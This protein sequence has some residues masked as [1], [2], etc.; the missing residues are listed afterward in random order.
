MLIRLLCLLF[1]SHAVQAN[2]G[3]DYPSI[4][5]CDE[6][7]FHWYCDLE[8][9]EK[10]KR[11][12]TPP[13][14]INDLKTAEALRL[15]LK[16][17]EDIAIM[18]PTD[19]HIKDYLTLWHATQEKGAIFADNWR[20]VVWQNPDLDYTQK[21]PA[22]NTAVKMYD[23]QRTQNEAQQLKKLAKNHGLIFFFKSDCQYC[24]AMAPTLKMLAGQFGIE[25]L[26]VSLDGKGIP[27]FPNPRDGRAQGAA[28]GVT[29][30]PALFIGSKDTAEHAPIGFGMMALSEI[31]NRIFV[32]TG[33]QPGDNF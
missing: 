15:E 18:Q 5:Q 11:D 2:H 23:V 1:F 19:A 14:D 25:V 30:V 28:W 22:N 9:I 6:D 27:H 26:G 29:R 16:R 31:V 3:L 32:L 24:H 4:W 21:R 12:A 33:S 8:Q 7:K 20:R 13:I 17:R 10:S